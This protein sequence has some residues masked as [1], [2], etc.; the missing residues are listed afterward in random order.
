VTYCGICGSDLAEFRDGPRLIRNDAH[1][2]TGQSPPITL[3]HEFAGKVV[4][5][6]DPALWPAGTRVTADAC[7]RCGQCDD[8]R[9]GAY[10]RCRY[11]GSI[12]LHSD[13]ALAE[14]LVVPEYCLVALPDT[15]SDQDGALAEPLAVGLHA[16]DRAVVRAAEH[17][18]I[19]GFGPIGAGAALL[20]QSA[21][22]R[23]HVVEIESGRRAQ[24]EALGFETI[25]AGNELPRRVRQRLRA[26]GA[27][28]VV[29]TTGSPTILAD[30]VRCARR[31]GRIV[32]AG[33]TSAPA[34]IDT[35]EIVLFERSLIG[36]LGYRNDVERVV[37]M[38]EAGL[39]EPA[40]LISE[41]VPLSEAADAVKS[42]AEKVEGRIKV[43]V[44]PGSI[45][46]D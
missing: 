37:H 18:L 27:D 41:I 39:V 38:I 7:W 36:S 22:G 42:L 21:G 9:E 1:P 3:G 25:E 32:M 19:L 12:G 24:A 17:V 14:R 13:G 20:A 23:V 11:G 40:G 30:A 6:S 4:S 34:T 26:G 28:V 5:A 46:T 16:L 35:S 31:G 45:C 29:E 44:K 15:V 2:L 8:C 10:H 43:L 33:I